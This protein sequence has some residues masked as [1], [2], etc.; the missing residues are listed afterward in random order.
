MW[1]CT[2]EAVLITPPEKKEYFEKIDFLYYQ[3]LLFILISK[4][5]TI[6]TKQKWP[7]MP[8]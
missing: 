5:D 6:F 4:K 7:G 1:D 8:V 3:K 2:T